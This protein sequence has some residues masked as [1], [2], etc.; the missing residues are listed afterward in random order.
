MIFCRSWPAAADRL[1]V[2]PRPMMAINVPV[3][4]AVMAPRFAMPLKGRDPHDVTK[5]VQELVHGRSPLTGL[6]CRWPSFSNEY[7]V[8][9]K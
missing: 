2:D 3:I 6:H 9:F 1:P 7:N 4:A 5:D 8:T